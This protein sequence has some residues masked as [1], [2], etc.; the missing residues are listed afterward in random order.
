MDVYLAN[1]RNVAERVRRVYDREALVVNAPMSL[2]PAGEQEPVPGLEPGFWLTVGRGRAYKNT[3]AVID[4]IRGTGSPLAVVGSP[5]PDEER[6]SSVKWLGV[7]SEAQLRWLYANARALVAVAHEDFGLTPVEANAFG[8]PVAVLRAGGYLETT[9]EGVSGAFIEQP[10]AAAVADALRQP[11]DVRP[12]RR[13]PQRRPVQPGRVRGAHGRG[14][15]RRGGRPPRRH[16][17][18]GPGRP[19]APAAG[20]RGRAGAGVLTVAAA[21]GARDPARG[22]AASVLLLGLAEWSAPIATNQHH[23]ARELGRQHDV[24]FAEGTGTRGPRLSPDDARRV[25]RRLR[26][27]APGPARPVP[28]GVSVLPLR[29]LPHAWRPGPAERALAATARPGAGRTRP[30]PRC[31]GRAPR[32]RT[33]WSSTPTWSSTTWWTCSTRTRASTSPATWRPSAGWR[34]RRTWPSAPARRSPRTC[35]TAGARRVETLLNVADTQVFLGAASPPGP[36]RREVVFAGA[37]T[38]TKLDTALLEGLLAALARGRA[39]HAGRPG[40]DLPRRPEDGQAARGRRGRRAP[41]RAA[42]RARPPPGRRRGR[43]SCRTP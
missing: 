31:C 12:G 21:D 13:P 17:R 4:G 19:R 3:R 43:R 39:A 18:R 36:R 38:A 35:A 32:T 42:A 27:A 7:V 25:L 26:G 5:P 24:L 8:T 20:P 9:V 6:R 34:P 14:D 33:A 41:G 28:P 16:R 23:V 11:A 37:L 15:R 40:R 10:T 2:D 30:G 1:S 22:D 29:L